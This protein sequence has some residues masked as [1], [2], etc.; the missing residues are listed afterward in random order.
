[1]PDPTFLPSDLDPDPVLLVLRYLVGTCLKKSIFN[2]VVV[3]KQLVFKPEFLYYVK[4]INF[5]R[6]RKS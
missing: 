6:G 1:L 4:H 3:E 5:F 2:F